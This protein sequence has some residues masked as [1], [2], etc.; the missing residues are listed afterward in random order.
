MLSLC[1]YCTT[2]CM[3]AVHTL[4]MHLTARHEAKNMLHAGW[5][6][7][8][9][10]WQVMRL[11]FVSHYMCS[12]FGF[13]TNKKTNL[14]WISL[15]WNKPSYSNACS[16]CEILLLGSQLSTIKLQERKWA[17]AI[18]GSQPLHFWHT[19]TQLTFQLYFI[20]VSPPPLLEAGLNLKVRS[21]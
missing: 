14:F 10:A 4:H 12:I 3:C 9:C 11:I 8:D 2:C 20:I 16:I 21:G 15:A 18:I 13:T 7:V 19:G 5:F 6:R 1:Y 17:T